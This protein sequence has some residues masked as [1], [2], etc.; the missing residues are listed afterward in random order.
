MADQV[1]MS[2]M[3]LA[4]SSLLVVLLIIPPLCWHFR[5]R[6]LGATVLVAWIIYLNFQTFVNAIV[7]HNDDIASWFR[8]FGLCDIEVKLQIAS[9]VGAPAALCCVLRALAKVLDTDRAS[10]V[11]SKAQIQRDNII[12]ITIC[13]VPAVLQ[14]AFHLIVQSERFYIFGMSGCIPAVSPTWVAILLIFVP[15]VILTLTDAYFSLLVLFRLYK[16][17]VTFS[18]ILASS[19]TSRSR[20]TRLYLLCIVW[21]LGY[22]SVQAYM[23][24]QNLSLYTTAYKWPVVHDA[25]KWRTITAVPSGGVIYYDRFVWLASGVLVF[26]FFGLGKEALASYR[27]TLVAMGLARI[28]PSLVASPEP[29]RS[30]SRASLMSSIMSYSSKARLFFLRSK[31]ARSEAGS[32]CMTSSSGKSDDDESFDSV[33]LEKQ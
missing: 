1:Y 3:A 17:R 19:N 9:Q 32:V 11:R 18:S 22:M 23:L 2:G 26:L 14:M 13:V 5:N 7:W 25:G 4:V 27:A 33:D 24:S 16:Y 6:N 8:G 12:D 10:A 31:N 15:P 20:F 30:N 21:T 28:F 29:K